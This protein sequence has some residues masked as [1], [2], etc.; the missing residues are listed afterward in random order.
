[1]LFQSDAY[2]LTVATLTGHC[3]LAFGEGY[4]A[5]MDNGPARRAGVSQL[6]QEAGDQLAEP[7]EVRLFLFFFRI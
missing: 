5:S 2:L 3:C 7:V 6:L 4:T 1:M